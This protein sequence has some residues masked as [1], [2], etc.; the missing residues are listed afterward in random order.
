MLVGAEVCRNQKAEL[1]D[2]LYFYP[3][4]YLPAFL[5]ELVLIDTSNNQFSVS[6]FIIAF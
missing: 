4:P 5:L 1:G 3:R 6:V 2:L